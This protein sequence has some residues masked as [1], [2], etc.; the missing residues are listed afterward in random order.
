MNMDFT[1]ILKRIAVP[2]GAEER[3]RSVLFQL[4]L[5]LEKMQDSR[6]RAV[7]PVELAYCLQKYNVPLFVQHDAAQLYLT[8]WNPIKDQIPDVDLV[9]KLQALYTMQV[10]DSL[11]CL[12]CTRESSRTS[13]MPTLPLPLYDMD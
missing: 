6:Q 5:L 3:E 8:F 12:S 10:K 9:E 7:R 13:C 11:V 4:F 2:K 1:K